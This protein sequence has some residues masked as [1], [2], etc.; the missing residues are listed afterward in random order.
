MRLSFKG[1]AQTL[2]FAGILSGMSGSLLAISSAPSAPIQGHA[3]VASALKFE[4]APVVTESVTLEYR[5]SDGDD[6]EELGSRYIWSI[7]DDD[8][9]ST[10]LSGAESATLSSIPE[11]A[12][13]KHLQAC[14]TPKTNEATTLP[15][16]GKPS[17]LAEVVAPPT[18]L[19]RDL[20]IAVK[21]ADGLYTVNN[22]LTGNYVYSGIGNDVS[23]AIFAP[24][25]QAESKLL[26]GEGIVTDKGMVADFKMTGLAGRKVELGV[27]PL[28]HYGGMGKVVVLKSNEYIYDPT[29]PPIVKSYSVTPTHGEATLPAVPYQLDR[30]GGSPG[31]QSEYR[32]TV[33]ETLVASGK[34]SG[35]AIP[36][37]TVATGIYGRVKHYLIPVN[38]AGIKGNEVDLG[39]SFGA[40]LDMTAVPAISN[41]KVTW[42]GAPTAP[43]VGTV[44]QASYIYEP[45]GGHIGQ[46]TK[47]VY[48]IYRADNDAGKRQW[49]GHYGGD[50]KQDSKETSKYTI[51][52]FTVPSQ[53]AGEE[54]ELL[55]LGVSPYG[56]AATS[57]SSVR[58]PQVSG[59]KEVITNPSAKP[60]VN[61]DALIGVGTMRTYLYFGVDN[62]TALANGGYPAQEI[63]YWWVGKQRK[64]GKETLYGPYQTL[65]QS[66]YFGGG[67]KMDDYISIRLQALNTYG[68]WGDVQ[69]VSMES[70]GRG[71]SGNGYFYDP[72]NTPI[73]PVVQS[74]ILDN[75]GI[76]GAGLR[77]G[78]LL[79]ATY[80]FTPT[81]GTKDQT[82]YS[83]NSAP[84]K[85]IT[86]AG[87][88]P[89][90]QI[91]E[92]DVGRAIV[93][94]M[95]Y[96]ENDGSGYSN[97]SELVKISTEGF[98]GSI[99]LENES[100]G[101]PE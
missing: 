32:T 40:V 42:S 59:S 9:K 33:G 97:N 1:L 44:L 71:P 39:N 45:N 80:S 2:M 48:R 37:H 78:K 58:I 65:N 94:Q 19:A 57:V 22:T 51:P 64:T 8:D 17:C 34:T 43:T 74:F 82:E 53:W 73:A 84:K 52:S 76:E 99:V 3:P 62:V 7:I 83:W 81:P 72:V 27:M 46:A 20:S 69:E 92:S 79:S 26:A 55:L 66:I 35:S 5:F 61:T 24:H 15:S 23:R 98:E 86:E 77:P 41:L 14:V 93:L 6:D 101:A 96:V 90:Y 95:K 54:L 89:T 88:V 13:N 50:V 91:Q 47:Y 60:S 70:L 29:L 68:I 49:L 100:S 67:F 56:V 10:P 36:A 18:P 30:A 75:N 31:D 4:P 16:Q 28:S 12:I 21:E 87:K 38:G 85:T 63:R 11:A 25:G